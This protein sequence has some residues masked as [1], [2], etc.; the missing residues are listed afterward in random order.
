[1]RATIPTIN[2]DQNTTM[3]TVMKNH[4]LQPQPPS[5]HIM[6]ITFSGTTAVDSSTVTP[7]GADAEGKHGPVRGLN[8]PYDPYAD[9]R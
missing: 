3:T 4:P 6:P 5:Y 2:S 8:G 1:M 9:D 7:R